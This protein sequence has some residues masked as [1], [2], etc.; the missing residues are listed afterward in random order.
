MPIHKIVNAVM[1]SSLAD[2]N[3]LLEYWSRERLMSVDAR[4]AWC[5]PDLKPLPF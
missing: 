3:W 2:P 1:A 5:D 4:R